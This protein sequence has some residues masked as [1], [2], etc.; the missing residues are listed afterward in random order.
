MKEW[1]VL[2]VCQSPRLE[3]TAPMCHGIHN[4]VPLGRERMV[5]LLWL[6]RA[7]QRFAC[8]ISHQWTRRSLPRC[9]RPSAQP[10]LPCHSLIIL[11]KEDLMWAD[12]S[13]WARQRAPFSPAS[14]SMRQLYANG[15]PKPQTSGH[16]EAMSAGK[17]GDNCRPLIQFTHTDWHMQQERKRDKKSF[18]AIPG[19]RSV[20]Q[21]RKVSPPQSSCKGSHSNTCKSN[22]PD[23]CHTKWTFRFDPEK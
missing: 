4:L 23:H 20:L 2:G 19:H 3:K 1:H 10:T 7:H 5:L 16:V 14:H 8:S 15:S 13:T 9:S 18:I 17:I 12:V 22:V 6:F 11:C 21:D